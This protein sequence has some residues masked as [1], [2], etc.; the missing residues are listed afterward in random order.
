MRRQ[1]FDLVIVGGGITGAGVAR[2]AAS[3]GMSVALVEA[4]DF[5]SGTSSRSSKMIHGGVR[6]LE[7]LEFGLVFEALSERKIL[8]D[9]A[10]HLVHPLRF[11]MPVYDW[12]RV[13]MF[14]LSLGMWLYDVLSLFEAPETHL[15]M[16]QDQTRDRLPLLNTSG[17]V[18]S[19][20][21]YDAYM[22][23]DR[24]AIE[25]LRSASQM[26]AVIANYTRVESVKYHDQKISAMICRDEITGEM[27]ELSGRHFVGSV[28]PWTDIFGKS[29]LN[30]WSRILRPTKGIHVTLDKSRL[31][32]RDA[33]VMA[34]DRKNRIVFGMPRRE[35]I[36]IGTTDTD[37][38]GDPAS[39]HSD[40]QDIEYLLSL[41][42]EYFPGANL[43]RQ[44]IISSYAGVRPLVHDGSATEGKTSREHKIWYDSRGITFVAGGKY[45][46]YRHMSEQIVKSA[47]ET[48]TPE[49][50]ARF[51][52]SSTKTP[53]NPRVT[54]ESLRRALAHVHEWAR[55]S[56]YSEAEVQTLVERHG[57]EA[58]ELLVR[59]RKDRFRN[60]WEMEA[61]HAIQNT[62]C[63]HLD[64][65]MIR[66]SPLFLSK[67][68]HG[69]SYV[70][71]ICD[72]FAQYLNWDEA[73]RSHE[74]QRYQK[75]SDL[76]LAWKN[77]VG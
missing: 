1:K 4:S 69:Q 51:A 9:I 63:F 66:R 60:A 14:K 25:T 42:T 27:F 2:E 24:L 37:F 71:G 19:F 17:L 15:R 64:D 62:M 75:H 56:G 77:T 46:T 70:R 52:K 47:L 26:G 57:E 45:T 40:S 48:F 20:A 55:E 10:P 68:D 49:E 31:P 23:D 73:E 16:D 41:C 72:V 5:A 36:V 76:E 58:E 3:R 29:I 35:M 50:R 34:D 67:A 54:T 43:K 61:F 6:Y 74:L 38:S 28:G 44:D 7:N 21:F 59:G 30:D 32:L 53:L 12:S 33:V 11:V 18:G 39:V 13:G 65:F 8:F 22:D